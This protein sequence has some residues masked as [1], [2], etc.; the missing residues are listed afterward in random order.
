[1]VADNQTTQ[2]C[3]NKDEDFAADAEYRAP[4]LTVFGYLVDVTL[5]GTGGMT[6]IDPPS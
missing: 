2:E 3:R 4:K 5:S 1:M 6:Q